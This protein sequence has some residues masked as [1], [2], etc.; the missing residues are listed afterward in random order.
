MSVGEYAALA[1]AL[2]GNGVR[3]GDHYWRQVRPCFFRPLLPFQEYDPSAVRVPKLAAI[4]GW[5]YGVAD[6]DRRNSY[7]NLLLFR[8]VHGY[9]LP[10]LTPKKQ[11]QVR[12]AAGLFTIRL[13]TNAA[14]FRQSAYPVYL[15]FYHRTRYKYLA[16]R[17]AEDEFSRWTDR[18]FR[19]PK[20]AILGGYRNGALEAVSVS[21]WVEETLLYSTFFCNDE[22]LHLCVADLMLHWTRSEVARCP[23]IKQIFAGMH[24]NE[25]GLSDFYLQRGCELVRKPALFRL[26]PIAAAIVKWWFPGK[27]RMI[28]GH[29]EAA[30]QNQFDGVTSRAEGRSM[31]SSQTARP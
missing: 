3:T 17:R 15:A 8:T 22:S 5:Q 18:L 29:L 25:R 10:C 14:E 31:P 27:H 2:D 20:I 26:S 24:K 7:L 11:R 19:F 4:G 28:A 21:Q 6:Q 13:I 12:L 30:G 16:E 23:G 1:R 9:A